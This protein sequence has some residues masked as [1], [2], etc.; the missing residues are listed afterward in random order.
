M[1]LREQ[2]FKDSEMSVSSTN[3][4]TL[5]L[6][7]PW[8]YVRVAQSSCASTALS[9]V[10]RGQLSVTEWRWVFLVSAVSHQEHCASLVYFLLFEVVSSVWILCFFNR[11]ADLILVVF[12]TNR[13]Y[14]ELSAGRVCG[15]IWVNI[16]EHNKGCESFLLLTFLCLFSSLL[17]RAP[18][19][20]LNCFISISILLMRCSV[21]TQACP[22]LFQYT[23]YSIVRR[24]WKL[25]PWPHS[26]LQTCVQIVGNT[27]KRCVCDL[28]VCVLWFALRNHDK[29]QTF[30]SNHI[31]VYLRES[32]QEEGELVISLCFDL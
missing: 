8:V 22:E 18:L 32:G 30:V 28:C 24:S 10:G 7:P 14:E 11:G 26:T 5:T 20:K 23:C 15:K 12:G 25:H 17:P 16:G 3:R 4:C 19:Q 6:T 9:S 1:L 31:E 27:Y 21:Q 2:T 29:P 13:N